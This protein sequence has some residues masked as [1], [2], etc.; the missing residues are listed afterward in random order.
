MHIIF[1]VNIVYHL[2]FFVKISPFVVEFGNTV[3]LPYKI[4][5][6]NC[7]MQVYRK[8]FFYLILKNYFLYLLCFKKSL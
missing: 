6:D 1:Y 4:T 7:K 5:N 3:D 8:I 2:I